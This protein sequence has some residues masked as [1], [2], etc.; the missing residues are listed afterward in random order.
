M[1]THDVINISSQVLNCKKFLIK[2]ARNK[3]IKPNKLYRMIELRL[4]RFMGAFNL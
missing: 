2:P 1:I 3:L 4:K